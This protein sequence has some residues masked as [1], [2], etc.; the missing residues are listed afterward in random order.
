MNRIAGIDV[1]A[2]EIWRQ[3][4]LSQLI[5]DNAISG[6]YSA[7][8]ELKDLSEVVTIAFR[9]HKKEMKT[10]SDTIAKVGFDFST[11]TRIEDFISNLPEELIPDVDSLEYDPIIEEEIKSKFEPYWN[12]TQDILSEM[13]GTTIDFKKDGL[14]LTVF[15]LVFSMLVNLLT[16]YV[17]QVLIPDPSLEETKRHNSVIEANQIKLLK[18]NERQLEVDKQ[19]LEEL[20]KLN[21]NNDKEDSE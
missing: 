17:E 11:I 3:N 18:V 5:N 20:R 16:S 12:G 10:L 4:N 1:M 13:T 21:A 15:L 19:Q 7:L 8:D 14:P 6:I 2:L 9:N